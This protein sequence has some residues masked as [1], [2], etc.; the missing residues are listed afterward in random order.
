MANDKTKKIFNERAQAI[1]NAVVQNFIRDGHPIG[2]KSL[3]SNTGIN[4]SSATIRNVLADLES[5][6]YIKSPH[7]SAGRIPTESGYRFFVDTLLQN[8]TIAKN[9]NIEQNFKI[10]SNSSQDIYSSTSNLLS[11]LT[12]LTG[13][14]M[15]PKQELLSLRQ[16]E[17]LPLS[18]KRVLAILVINEKE[19][20]NR[21]L[22]TDKDYSTNELLQM[23]NFL[24]SHLA[25]K[26][27]SGA[28]KQILRQMK[29][30]RESMNEQMNSAI[31]MAENIFSDDIS[32]EDY[33]VAG[34]TNLMEFAEL[35]S[36]EKLKEIFNA[37]NQKREILQLL[38]KCRC[39]EGMKIFI[40]QE[41][42]YQVFDGCS[43]VT[44]P[45]SSAGKPVGVVGVIGPTRM[46]YDRVIPV[47]DMT[48]KLLSSAL[49][50]E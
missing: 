19:V 29:L 43:L 8:K 46:A 38:E 34:E 17:F 13:I 24:N 4:L 26:D 23:S 16:V 20:E 50:K 32:A 2:S 5:L 22:N 15:L 9:L 36:I 41:S 35:S 7:T 21:I 45:Y 27:L 44:A 11:G 28:R 33:V 47:V 18:D 30:D 48:S 25:G 39:S 1:L 3:I 10:G 37:F 42:G 40:G 14:V 31:D 12:S 6:G 49:K